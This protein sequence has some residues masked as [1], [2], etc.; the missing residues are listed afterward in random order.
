MGLKQM[1]V[2]DFIR[3]FV[4]SSLRGI[5]YRLMVQWDGQQNVDLAFYDID[6]LQ[7]RLKESKEIYK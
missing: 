5:F 3:K 7:A 4:P 1:C 6:V 2:H